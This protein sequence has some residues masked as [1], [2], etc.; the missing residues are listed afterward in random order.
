MMLKVVFA[1]LF[2]VILASAESAFDSEFIEQETDYR[3]MQKD[4]ALKARENRS[5]LEAFLQEKEKH[6]K[7]VKKA[8]DIY[9][10]DKLGA[11]PNR[12]PAFVQEDAD[13]AEKALAQIDRQKAFEKFINEKY[14][15]DEARLRVQSK[16]NSKKLRVREQ[17]PWNEN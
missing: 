7:E 14:A 3:Q 9:L 15:R 8:L 2:F 4:K 5:G 13:T 10:D 6:E 17:E 16:F 12:A 11:H 1:G